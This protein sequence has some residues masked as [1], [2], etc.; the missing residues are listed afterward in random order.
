MLWVT[1]FLE[2]RA[3]HFAGSDY[4]REAPHLDQLC[5]QLREALVALE[6]ADA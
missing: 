6:N 2:A 4:A 3:E 5:Q 1:M